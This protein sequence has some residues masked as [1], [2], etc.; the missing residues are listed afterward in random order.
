MTARVDAHAL[1]SAD[2]DLVQR[3]IYYLH[4]GLGDL[5]K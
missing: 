1:L 2:F 3:V 4:A 5:K